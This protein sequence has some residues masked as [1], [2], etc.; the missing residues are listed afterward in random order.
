M[1]GEILQSGVVARGIERIQ[2]S[3]FRNR[4]SAQITEIALVNNDAALQARD[5]G[6]RVFARRVAAED[7]PRIWLSRVIAPRFSVEVRNE[8]GKP[9]W[10]GQ[11]DAITVPQALATAVTLFDRKEHAAAAASSGEA[12]VLVGAAA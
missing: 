7:D 9:Q 2:K 10:A 3:G 5:S 8:G 4:G 6:L 11:V 1:K 12:K